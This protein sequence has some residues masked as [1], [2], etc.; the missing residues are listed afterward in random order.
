[1]ARAVHYAHQHGVLH[2]DLKPANILLDETGEPFVADFGIAELLD[3]N[4]D[5]AQ[6][7]TVIG[8]PSY[9]SPEQCAGGTTS[10]TTVTDVFSLGA[11]L[12]QLLTG[13]PP[14]QAAT[15]VATMQQVIEQEPPAIRSLNRSVDPDLETIS[16][17]CLNKDPQ[18][19]YASA[20]VVADDLDRWLA[21]EPIAARPVTQ[22]ERV[23]RWCVRKPVLATLSGS[24][25]PAQS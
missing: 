11:I 5:T 4:R 3:G 23:W 20:E 14:F 22:F 7:M 21:G 15:P 24:A 13:R 2:R 12:Y 17:K 19:R 16:I 1:M 6:S 18:R 9:M 25:L 8:T 10:L